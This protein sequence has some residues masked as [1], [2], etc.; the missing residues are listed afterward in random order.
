MCDE[1]TGECTFLLFFYVIL[2]KWNE[3]NNMSSMLLK[4]KKEFFLVVFIILYN[5]YEEKVLNLHET[6][7]I[8]A[9]FGTQIIISW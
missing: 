6:W 4:L 1:Q 8:I 9:A 7:N 3:M 2:V 5:V